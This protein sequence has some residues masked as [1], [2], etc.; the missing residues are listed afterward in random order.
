MRVCCLAF[1]CYAFITI[2]AISGCF[3]PSYSCSHKFTLKVGLYNASSLLH[4]SKSLREVLAGSAF[5]LM[6]WVQL[7][8]KAPHVNGF[9]VCLQTVRP[10][11]KK[12]TR[13]AKLECLKIHSG[14]VRVMEK[15]WNQIWLL[16]SV[17]RY[18]V[19]LCGPVLVY[20]NKYSLTSSVK[21]YLMLL[22]QCCLCF[23][24]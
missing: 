21:C 22:C 6:P 8:V 4:S 3:V 17:C 9:S 11:Y 15:H 16:Q 18:L 13:D 12:H 19:L 2:S 20:V 14:A 5:P 24:N 1:C 10:W 23:H 7:C